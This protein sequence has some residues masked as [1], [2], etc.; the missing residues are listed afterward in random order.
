M[1]FLIFKVLQPSRV[2]I[3]KVGIVLEGVSLIRLIIAIMVYTH[4]SQFIQK[5]FVNRGLAWVEFANEHIEHLSLF[6]SYFFLLN[7]SKSSIYGLLFFLNFLLA[8]HGRDFFLI[9]DKFSAETD[10]A[11]LMHLHVDFDEELG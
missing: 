5:S 2:K 11:A 7:Q 4:A 6:F 8:C 1:L 10:G 3:Y 9:D